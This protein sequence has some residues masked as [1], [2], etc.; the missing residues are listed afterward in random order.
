MGATTRRR[1][2]TPAQQAL[3]AAR[4][5]EE[6]RSL[7][8]SAASTAASMPPA[9]LEV[10]LPIAGAGYVLRRLD[11]SDFLLAGAI[12]QPCTQIVR[13]MVTEGIGPVQTDPETQKDY[14][15]TAAALARAAIIIPP[16]AFLD[17]EMEAS[18]IDPAECRPMFVE[19][20]PGEDQAVLVGGHVDVPPAGTPW[21]RFSPHDLSMIATVVAL[22]APAAVSRF[23]GQPDGDVERVDAV[24]GEPGAD[25]AVVAA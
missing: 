23:R 25:A 11:L 20:D 3:A 13:R 14:L 5:K 16:D 22:N 7:Y 12:P 24:E 8:A 10:F 19:A 1:R 6:R 21:A 15:D 17:G 2:P 4:A 9:C 18:D